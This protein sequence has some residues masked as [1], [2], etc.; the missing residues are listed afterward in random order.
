MQP[1]DMY[2]FDT[3]VILSGWDRLPCF[4]MSHAGHGT[5]SYGLSLFVSSGPIAFFVQH[6]FGGIYTDPVVAEERIAAT[7]ARVRYFLTPLEERAEPARWLVL[8]SDFRRVARLIDLELVAPVGDRTPPLADPVNPPDG[9]R[10]GIEDVD[11]QDHLW[12]AIIEKFPA[13][14]FTPDAERDT[15]RNQARLAHQHGGVAA[16]PNGLRYEVVAAGDPVVPT[17]NA[18]EEG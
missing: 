2:L 9:Q 14:D 17:A 8:Y 11:R 13:V 5:N 6:G 16:C 7:Y 10:G 3:D 4:V 12:R 18:F 1:E 15:R